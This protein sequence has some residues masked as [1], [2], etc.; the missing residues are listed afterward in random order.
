MTTD[1]KEVGRQAFANGEP[2]APMLNPQVREA[3]A[4]LPVGGGA[5]DIMR[6]FSEGWHAANLAQ[7]IDL[8]D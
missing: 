2:A 1:F 5:A 6:A 7:P 3:I 4:D 8:E